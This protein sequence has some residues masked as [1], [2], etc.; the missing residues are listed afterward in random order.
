MKKLHHY[1]SMLGFTVLACLLI[2]AA[3]LC[4]IIKTTLMKPEFYMDNIRDSKADEAVYNE[5]DKYFTQ[6][7]RPTDIPKEV[8]TNTLTQDKVTGS[9]KQLAK[10]SVMYITGKSFAKPE[11][12]YDFETLENDITQYVETYSEENGIEKDDEYY[13]LINK[14]VESCETQIR[15][16]MDVM[17][18]KKLADSPSVR[19]LRKLSPYVNAGIVMTLIM[20]A[21]ILFAMYITDK[22]HPF[23]LLYWVGCALFASS[24]IMLIPSVYIKHTNFFD[25]F[26][27][28][29][30]SIYRAMTGL[31]YSVTDRIFSLNLV[32][33]I[34]GV[35][36]IIATQIIY[37]IRVHRS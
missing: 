3:Q 4:I 31:L 30:E 8:F 9:T 7:Q 37:V 13:D 33:A 22:H 2:T 21:A 10:A 29:N 1:P 35:T 26:F 17:M 25:G 34:A 32:L 11:V 28:E 6:L 20:F 36:M 12:L 27:V 19:G 15:S 24:A 16:K 18:L 23:D 5:L 14:T